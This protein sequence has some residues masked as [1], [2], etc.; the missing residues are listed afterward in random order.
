MT[1]NDLEARVRTLEDIEAIRK[2]K[3]TYCDICDLGLQDPEVL[4]SL[5]QHFTEDARVDFG[6]GEGSA[7]RGKDA[8]RVFFGQVVGAAVSFSMHMLHNSFIEIDGDRATGSWYFEAPTTNSATGE[9]QWMAGRYVEEY[10][11]QGGTWKFD[12]IKTE[13]NYIAPYGEGWAKASKDIR[14]QAAGTSEK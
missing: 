5:L 6:M 4:E 8:L 12:S 10:V 3:A 2:L 9:A 14:A 7:F 11:R 13:W 1:Q